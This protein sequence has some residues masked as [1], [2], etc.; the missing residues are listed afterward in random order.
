MRDQRLF[1]SRIHAHSL[2]P[3]DLP[4]DIQLYLR[5]QW[6]DPIL[7]MLT[8]RR[9]DAKSRHTK[10]Q[11]AVLVTQVIGQVGCDITG[12]IRGTEDERGFAFSHEG[13]PHRINTWCRRDTSVV[14]Q[15]TLTIEY[16]SLQPRNAV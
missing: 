12:V 14:A 15:A 11:A 9:A 2:T 5:Y 6:P 13:Q 3:F 10:S 8:R 7:K 1:H 16:R 4:V